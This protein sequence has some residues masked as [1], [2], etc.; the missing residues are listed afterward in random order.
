MSS[1]KG[2]VAAILVH[3]WLEAVML[4]SRCGL[5]LL[6]TVFSFSLLLPPSAFA[7]GVSAFDGN[8]LLKECKAYVNLLSLRDVQDKDDPDVLR[9]QARGDYVNGMHCLGYVTGVA[10]S[11]QIN[12]PPSTAALDPKKHFCLSDGVTPN[13]TVRVI[14]K[15]LEDHPARLH[16]LAIGLVL[17]ALKDNFPCKPQH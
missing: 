5:F 15:W 17:S 12:E 13:Q 7:S 3:V 10:D 6:T 11:Y 4:A 9:A 1:S 14:A 16:E 2:V 8:Q